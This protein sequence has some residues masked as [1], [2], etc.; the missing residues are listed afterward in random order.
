[1]TRFIS[2]K[3]FILLL[4]VPSFFLSSEFLMVLDGIVLGSYSDD[5]PDGATGPFQFCDRFYA[6][7]ELKP[8]LYIYI[9][10]Y[11]YIYESHLIIRQVFLRF[12]L[13][14]MVHI[15]CA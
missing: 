3:L 13:V 8:V 7:F 14:I 2:F 1:M 6:V 15:L 5:H 12:L 11:I 4:H 9:Y 10:I